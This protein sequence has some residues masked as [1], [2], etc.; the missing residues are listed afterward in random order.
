VKEPVSSGEELSALLQA[1]KDS[2]D[3]A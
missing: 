3:Y 1:E 2:P